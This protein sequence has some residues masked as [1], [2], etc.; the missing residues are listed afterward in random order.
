MG[1]SFAGKRQKSVASLTFDQEGMESMH[2]RC[3]FQSR[4]VSEPALSQAKTG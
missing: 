1:V 4:E 3:T 2:P